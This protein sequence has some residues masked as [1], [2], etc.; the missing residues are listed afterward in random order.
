[1]GTCGILLNG[2][3]MYFGIMF[4]NIHYMVVQVIA[5]MT[6]V[7]W[8]LSLSYFWVFRSNR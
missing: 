4:E 6:M 3:V 5:A 7:L 2:L 1:M 8:S